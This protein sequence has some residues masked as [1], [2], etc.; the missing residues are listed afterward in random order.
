M[1][2]NKIILSLIAVSA[3]TT[4]AYAENVS[5]SDFE[6]LE[7]IV[8]KNETKSLSDTINWSGDLRLRNDNFTYEK[9]YVTVS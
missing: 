1:E 7:E 3:L 2:I 5:Y 4:G 6:E 9:G 8:E